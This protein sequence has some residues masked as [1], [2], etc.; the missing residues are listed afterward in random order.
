MALLDRILRVDPSKRIRL[1]SILAD[2]LIKS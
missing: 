1:G 2:P